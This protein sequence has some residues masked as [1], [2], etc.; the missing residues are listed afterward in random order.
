M[1]GDLSKLQKPGDSLEQVITFHQIYQEGMKEQAGLVKLEGWKVKFDTDR[2]GKDVLVV[3]GMGVKH[4]GAQRYVE[5]TV[6]FW[7]GLYETTV[8]TRDAPG[9]SVLERQKM[10]CEVSFWRR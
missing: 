10:N 7:E 8:T 3:A 5:F 6:P 1:Y 9:G 2:A 4:E